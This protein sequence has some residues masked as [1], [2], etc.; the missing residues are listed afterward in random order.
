MLKN[1]RPKFICIKSTYVTATVA[2]R[3]D[4]YVLQN[5]IHTSDTTVLICTDKL[6]LYLTFP[7][8]IIVN[9]KYVRF[10]RLYSYS[11]EEITK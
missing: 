4:L 10:C 7:I 3:T 6:I 5:L 8:D 11:G 9:I 2:L 1:V